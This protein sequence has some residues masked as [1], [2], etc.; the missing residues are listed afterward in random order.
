LAKQSKKM[1]P[2]HHFLVTFTVPEELRPLPRAHQT[3]GY[4]ELFRCGSQTIIDV[5]Q[6][7]KSLKDCQIIACDQDSVM[8]RYTSSGTKVSKTRRVTGEQFVHSFTQHILPSGFQKVHHYGWMSANC[9][10]KFAE[11]KWLVWLFL[12]WTYWLGSAFGRPSE[13]PSSPKM[14]CARCGGEMIAIYVIPDRPILPGPVPQA[15]PEHSVAYL[16]SGKS[17]PCHTHSPVRRI[18]KIGVSRPAWRCALKRHVEPEPSPSGI[19][20]GLENDR[21]RR[22]ILFRHEPAMARK[23]WNGADLVPS[24]PCS[25]EQNPRTAGGAPPEK[26]CSSHRPGFL[27]RGFELRL[28]FSGADRVLS[29]RSIPL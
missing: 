15:L 9:G 14:R 5:A 4:G 26:R 10:L 24:E 3:V 22:V 6:S 19:D 18:P 21:E 7:T 29:I 20:D 27:N 11:V 2:V 25:S 12:G 13:P 8:Y 17:A 23:W 16:D 1:L 28:T